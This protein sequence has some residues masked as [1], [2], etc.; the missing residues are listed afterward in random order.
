MLFD[1]LVQAYKDYRQ[2]AH[3]T[4]EEFA[5]RLNDA[6]GGSDVVFILSDFLNQFLPY[7]S[8]CPDNFLHLSES[9]V[10]PG[11]TVM[12]APDG[13]DISSACGRRQEDFPIK[14]KAAQEIIRKYVELQKNSMSGCRGLSPMSSESVFEALMDYVLEKVVGTT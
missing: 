14:N 6:H 4:I 13:Y 3:S 10:F 12:L 5:T 8:D 11:L 9:L 2:E 1:K 7:K